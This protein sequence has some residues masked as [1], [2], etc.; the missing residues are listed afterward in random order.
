MAWPSCGHGAVHTKLAGLLPQNLVCWE[1]GDLYSI[2]GP[3]KRLG[4]SPGWILA[5]GV[6]QLAAQG[7]LTGKSSWRERVD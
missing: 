7:G 6:C 3:T 4:D 1:T 2:H 5:K